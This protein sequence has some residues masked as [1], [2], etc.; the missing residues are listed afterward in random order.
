MN[1]DTEPEADAR[2][3]SCT[4]TGMIGPTIEPI[5]LWYLAEVDTDAST[6]AHT[7]T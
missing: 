1:E 2:T 5:T 7:H 6:Y 4:H 3:H